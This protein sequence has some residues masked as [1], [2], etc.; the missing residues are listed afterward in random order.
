MAYG[1]LKI[2]TVVT[3]T[4]TITL[5]NLLDGSAGSITG[6]MLS[7]GTITDVDISGTA[8]I[9]VSKLAD[10]AARQLLQ[11]DAAGTGV[12]WSSNIDV[13]G[14]LDVT[15]VATFDAA[16][17]GAV[18]S[19]TSAST[20]TINMAVA[21]NFSLTL[22]HNVTLANPTNLVAGQSGIITVTQAASGGP[23]TL[24]YGS[25]W[26]FSGGTLPSKTI[27]AS[28]VDVLAYYVES[29]TRITARLLTDTK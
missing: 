23:Y 29:S 17:R 21:N 19:L 18:G 25:Y 8:G 22:G 11:T 13:P 12:E 16:S 24:S 6:T 4:K 14:T 7:D 3:G 5:D 20:V 26:K 9:A 27:T 28:S 10:G 2:D 1:S 15:G